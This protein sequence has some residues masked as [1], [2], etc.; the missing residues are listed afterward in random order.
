ME[1]VFNDSVYFSNGSQSD[2]LESNLVQDYTQAGLGGDDINEDFFLPF[3]VKNCDNSSSDI[4]EVTE[5][6]SICNLGKC[7]VSDT[8]PDGDSVSDNI[9]DL[10]TTDIDVQHSDSQFAKDSMDN[11]SHIFT[12]K[13]DWVS[14][15]NNENH[16][17]VKPLVK[18][19]SCKD[20]EIKNSFSY[21]DVSITG[22]NNQFKVNG[23]VY[24]HVIKG[25]SKCVGVSFHGRGKFSYLKPRGFIAQ[26]CSAM[27]Y[28]RVVSNVVASFEPSQIRFPIGNTG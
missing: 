26:D 14:Q 11:I 27:D 17:L 9:S 3:L 23:N 28:L 6:N 21:S 19:H 13:C 25:A 24:Q 20:M 4:I 2:M 7:T 1:G 10:Q 15:F 16:V 5:N 18:N 22:E 12:S 8:L